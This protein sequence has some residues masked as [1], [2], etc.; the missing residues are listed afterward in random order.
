MTFKDL[1]ISPDTRVKY[2]E[3][4]NLKK[5]PTAYLMNPDGTD[6]FVTG[7]DA[8]TAVLIAKAVGATIE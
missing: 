6:L 1:V 4:K 2:T 3:R 5:P 8:N 7:N